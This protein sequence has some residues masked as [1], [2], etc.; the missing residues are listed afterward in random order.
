MA[1]GQGIGGFPFF[2]WEK[3]K[4]EQDEGGGD[5]ILWAL[6]RVVSSRGRQRQDSEKD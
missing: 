4:K 5:A 2:I 6:S 1:N 3:Q